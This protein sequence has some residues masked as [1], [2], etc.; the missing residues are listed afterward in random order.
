MV[1]PVAPSFEI[2]LVAISVPGSFRVD[3]GDRSLCTDPQ[4][5]CFRTKDGAFAVDESKLLEAFFEKLPGLF[6]SIGRRAVAAYTEKDMSLIVA[7]VE[8]GRDTF[9]ALD[10]GSFIRHGNWWCLSAL[11]SL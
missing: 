9:E 4:A 2:R 3:D 7:E 1:G 10:C 6:L 11:S 5:V 8:F